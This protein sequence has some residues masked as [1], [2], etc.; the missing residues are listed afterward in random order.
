MVRGKGHA[1]PQQASAYPFSI[2]GEAFVPAALPNVKSGDL[3]EI[4]VYAHNFGSEVSDIKYTG[5]ILGEDGRPH[6]RAELHLV[7]AGADEPGAQ[8]LLLQFTP[9]GLDPGRYS[10][11]VKLQ[12]A[13]G[14]SSESILPFDVH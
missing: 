11:A 13:S 8:A 3:R 5:R 7:R 12:N 14:K 9:H 2:G 1:P 10:L 4:C 6:G